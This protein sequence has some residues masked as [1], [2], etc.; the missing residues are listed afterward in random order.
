M[1]NNETNFTDNLKFFLWVLILAF[2]FYYPT[3][4][5]EGEKN[6]Q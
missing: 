5:N 3:P 2:L 1:N 4:L 6:E